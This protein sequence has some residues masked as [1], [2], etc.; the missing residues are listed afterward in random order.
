MLIVILIYDQLMFRPL[1]AW[2]DRF[3]VDSEQSEDQPQSW[4]LT[5]Y[6]RSR[7]LDVLTAPFDPMMRW[8]YH[9]Q[10][11]SFGVRAAFRDTDSRFAEYRLVSCPGRAGGSSGAYQVSALPCQSDLADLGLALGSGLYHGAGAG[12][13]RARQRDLDAHRRLCGPAA[14]I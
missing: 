5:M 2:A 3:R 7:L 14:R 12:A 1:V 11:P 13:D 10:P 8:S 4:A 9:F 6:R